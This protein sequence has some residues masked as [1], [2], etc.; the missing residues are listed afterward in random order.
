MLPRL[1]SPI[2]DA[3]GRYRIKRLLARGGQG[4]VY[5]ADDPEL[6]RTVV[7]KTVATATLDPSGLARLRREA[8]LTGRIDHP[9]ICPVLDLLGVDGIEYVIMPFIEGETL[10]ARV[11]RHRAQ[12]V[13]VDAVTI[14][15]LAAEST[16]DPSGVPEAASP[17]S[18]AGKP[19]SDLRRLVR[20]L[21]RVA[22]AVHEAHECGVIHRDL[23]PGNIMI[24]RNGEPV[25]LDF[26]LALDET[27]STRMTR[28]GATLGTPSYMAPEQIRGDHGRVG[29]ATDVHALGVVLYELL[30]GRLPYE[31]RSVQAVFQ[32]ILDGTFT[33]PRKINPRIT[34][35]L[36]TVCLKAMDID[37]G[38]RYPTAS[39]LALDLRNVRT[40]RPTV[41]RPPSWIGRTWR[42]MRRSPWVSSLAI[43][44][45]ILLVVAGYLTR[46]LFI[47]TENTEDLDA[48]NGIIM[49][50]LKNRDPSPAHLNRLRQLNLPPGALEAFRRNPLDP[51]TAS[52]LYRMVRQRTGETGYGDRL[53]SPRATIADPAPLFRFQVPE[54]AVADA[55]TAIIEITGP[56][57]SFEESV[58]ATRANTTPPVNHFH[59]MSV[60]LSRSLAVGCDWTWSV[61]LE[62]ISRDV[63]GPE[64]ATFRIAEADRKRAVL[65]SVPALGRPASDTLLRASALIAAGFAEGA[66][67]E[68]ASFPDGAT[69]EE[70]I[71]RFHLLAR[72]HD[73]LRDAEAIKRALAR[74]RELAAKR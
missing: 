4:V 31:D 64:P 2:P 49:A 37:P 55:C 43:F 68:L 21:E 47:A 73:L 25:V 41:A 36:E 61:R 29:R 9:A 11:E 24:K 19:P 23:K 56:E 74:I 71:F 27:V 35:D 28:S 57:G 1:E 20:F 54:G 33:R 66:V 65:D 63:Y 34:R 7:I 58:V 3:V 45:L 59:V 8:R 14:P 10:Q 60:R 50:T 38:R 42:R 39:D 67:A 15:Q 22:L 32:K 6:G 30:T 70:R 17:N 18:S 44:S 52:E 40:L 26:G 53:I 16:D 62:G 51:A 72:A 46:R 48:F 69:R 13:G 12:A 5:L